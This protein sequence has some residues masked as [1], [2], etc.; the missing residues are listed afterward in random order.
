M[1]QPSPD[2]ASAPDRQQRDGTAF[3]GAFGK[4]TG[5]SDLCFVEGQLPEDGDGVVDDPPAKQLERCLQN[6]DA[7]L[8]RHGR[9]PSDVLQLTLYL[10]DLDAYEEVNDAYEAYFDDTY[11]ARTT[12]GVSELLGGAAVTVDAVVAL[13]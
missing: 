2:R 5:E 4:T 1:Q 3:V 11:P 9:D 12:V 8:D 6:L 10:T 7:Q 13:E